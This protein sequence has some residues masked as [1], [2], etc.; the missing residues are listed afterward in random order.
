MNLQKLLNR[1][2]TRMFGNVRK[3]IIQVLIEK[4]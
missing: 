2:N 1:D 4:H 3:R